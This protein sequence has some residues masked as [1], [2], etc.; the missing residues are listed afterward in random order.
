MATVESLQRRTA[1]REGPQR[2]L[3]A[4]CLEIECPRDGRRGHRP[5]PLH[6]GPVIPVRGFS[7][8]HPRVKP[9][10][11]GLR[12][13]I[14]F[15]RAHPEI[16]PTRRVLDMLTPSAPSACSM[17]PARPTPLLSF[18]QARTEKDLEEPV[19][20]FD[21]WAATKLLQ[22]FVELRWREVKNAFPLAVADGV[23]TGPT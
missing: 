19:L 13:R 23:G 4:K 11:L 21:K 16:C 5:V 1:G 2:I 10:K 15:S 3:Q 8:P 18:L 17:D 12:Q 9:S 7:F 22:F 14:P 6:L 20:P